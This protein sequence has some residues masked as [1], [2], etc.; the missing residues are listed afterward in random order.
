MNPSRRKFLRRSAA[1]TGAGLFGNLSWL[2]AEYAN[3]QSLSGY[4]ALVGVFLFGGN[5]ANNT[6]VPIT[7][8]A[9]Y[10]A[11]RTAA[12]NVQIPQAQLLPIAPKSGPNA[13][14]SFGLHPDLVELAPLYAQ[15]KLA[16]ICNA[17]MLVAP[18]A[19]QW[20]I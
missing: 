13:G 7:D 6:V 2:G 16:V 9:S 12:S 8:Y 4:K 20:S 18:L 19:R 1:L 3:A 15:G 14:Q 11:V 10:A 17:G 5:D